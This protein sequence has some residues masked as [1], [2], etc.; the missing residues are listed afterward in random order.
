M[1]YKVYLAKLKRTNKWPK[2]VYKVGITGSSDAMKRLTYNGPDEPNPISDTF[3]D[4]KVMNSIWVESREAA[5]KIES[6]I[7]ESIRASKGDKYFHNWFEP[8]QF[9]GVTETRKWDY[10]EIQSIF[11]MMNQYK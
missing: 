7:M 5:E 9:S 1:K 2:C 3:P 10:N 4:I 8:T 6:A 11:E